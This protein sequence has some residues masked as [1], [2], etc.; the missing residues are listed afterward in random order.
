MKVPVTIF[1]ALMIVLSVGIMVVFLIVLGDC[2]GAI[3]EYVTERLCQCL[4]GM[5]E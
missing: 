1:L 3:Y 4:V 2:A 5:W